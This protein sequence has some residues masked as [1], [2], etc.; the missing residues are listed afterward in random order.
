MVNLAPNCQFSEIG[1]CIL[2]ILML[3]KPSYRDPVWKIWNFLIGLQVQQP[4]VHWEQF[5]RNLNCLIIVVN[6]SWFFSDLWQHKPIVMSIFLILQ[7][8]KP[9]SYSNLFCLTEITNLSISS[10]GFGNNCKPIRRFSEAMSTPTGKL[11]GKYLV[12][13]EHILNP[14]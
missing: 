13:Q 12:H 9:I 1:N 5:T 14:L 8:L 3:L 4:G 7:H 6:L 10:D 2:Y 11:S